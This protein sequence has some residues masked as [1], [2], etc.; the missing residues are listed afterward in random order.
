MT[1]QT[2]K[3]ICCLCLNQCTIFNRT[4]LDQKEF[5]SLVMSSLIE[6]MVEKTIIVTKN[7]APSLKSSC[8]LAILNSLPD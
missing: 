3:T 8:G 1:I 2:L 7:V 5:E 4:K 6:L